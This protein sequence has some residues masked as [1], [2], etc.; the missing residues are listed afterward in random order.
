MNLNRKQ[1]RAPKSIQDNTNQKH[2]LELECLFLKLQVQ[3]TNWEEIVSV[4]NQITV[5]E[6]QVE[7]FYKRCGIH[8]ELRKETWRT[9]QDMWLWIIKDY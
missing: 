5:L 4:E 2:F 9:G 8:K 3:E 6:G 7:V 1:G